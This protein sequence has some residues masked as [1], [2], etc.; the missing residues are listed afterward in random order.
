VSTTSGSPDKAAVTMDEQEID[1]ERSRS[2]RVTPGQPAYLGSVDLEGRTGIPAST[3]RYWAM[4]DV[5]PRS[6][7]LG[8]RRLWR[9]S[10]VEEW[11]DA[12]EA[13]TATGGGR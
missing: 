13:A 2:A 9:W 5:G 10:D 8:R 1:R 4:N 6:F 12:Q 3:W 11:I 7:K